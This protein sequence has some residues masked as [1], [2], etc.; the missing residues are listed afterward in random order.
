MEFTLVIYAIVPFRNVVRAY[1]CALLCVR[2]A[3]LKP[4]QKQCRIH[5]KV[6]NEIEASAELCRKCLC[7]TAANAHTF[8]R[9][10][11]KKRERRTKP[12]KKNKTR[13]SR[14]PLHWL[15]LSFLSNW[16]TEYRN[17]SP[18][19]HLSVE[20]KRKKI[21]L[22][23]PNCCNETCASTS[24]TPSNELVVFIFFHFVSIAAHFCIFFSIFE[25][26]VI[27]WWIVNHHEY[28]L[29]RSFYDWF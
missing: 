11:K 4:N 3:E 24:L 29:F 6:E 2:E 17:R 5:F 26:F 7:G 14:M 27:T 15:T 16:G 22:F 20:K 8:A 21:N 18:I 10:L 1:H 13:P 9:E 19:S 28:F 23:R 12:K 25:Y